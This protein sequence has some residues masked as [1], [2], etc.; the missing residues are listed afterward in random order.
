LAGDHRAGGGGVDVTDHDQPVGPVRHRDLFIGDHHAAGL[1]GMTAG[2]DAE[3]VIGLRQ[4]QVREDR[5][6]H[7]GIVMLAG[8]DQHR[9]EIGRSGQRVPERRHLHEI[10]PGRCDEMD[11]LSHGT[12][13][14]EKP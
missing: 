9:L 1:L 4:R 8:V 5:V 10:G 11:A 13:V 3:M 14:A 12:Q 2:A 6:R 7:V